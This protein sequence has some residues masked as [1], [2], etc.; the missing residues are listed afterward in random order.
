MGG[1][2]D[3]RQDV[4]GVVAPLTRAV[5]RVSQSLG[6][7]GMEG[8]DKIQVRSPIRG[9]AGRHRQLIGL[10]QI[11]GAPFFFGHPAVRGQ[12]QQPAGFLLRQGPPLDGIGTKNPPAITSGARRSAIWARGAD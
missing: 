7:G 1:I 12:V 5:V 11:E 10:F 2:A 8:A 9:G 3:M 4:L 6:N